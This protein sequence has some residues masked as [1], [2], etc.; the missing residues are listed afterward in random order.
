MYINWE[1]KVGWQCLERQKRRR[2]LSKANKSMTEERN[3]TRPFI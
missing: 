2:E 1:F 3:G